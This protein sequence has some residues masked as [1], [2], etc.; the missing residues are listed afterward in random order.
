MLQQVTTYGI[1]QLEHGS[2]PTSYIPTY[3]SSQ[4]RAAELM[5]VENLQSN[6][7]LG[8]NEGTVFV[9]WEGITN[10]SNYK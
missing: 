10:I 5:S 4:T 8:A 3:G 9:D 1:A 7:I 2:Y 6:N